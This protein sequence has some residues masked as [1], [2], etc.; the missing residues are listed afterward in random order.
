[1]NKRLEDSA[2]AIT[3]IEIEA[4][5]PKAAISVSA[6]ACDLDLH[7]DEALINPYP[8][9]RRM[10]DLGAVV[11]MERYDMFALGRFKDVREAAANWEVFSSAQGVGLSAFGNMATRG[12]TL[13]S[14]APLHD[15]LRKVV[16]KP[17]LPSAMK[18]LSGQIAEEAES[19][20]EK[21][22]AR[23]EFD[24]VADLAWHL[25]LTIV[26]KLVGIDEQS[27]Q[28]MPA[29]S[30]AAFN[31]FGPDNER[32]KASL[33]ALGE[34]IGYLA[35]PDLRD[36]LA[37]GGWGAQ[38]Y[39]AADRGE[40]DHSHC[41]TMLGDYLGPSLD[42]TMSATASAIWLLGQN[43]DQWA[44]IRE[45]PS[46]IPN[47]VLEVIRLESPIQCFTRVASQDIEIEGVC[48]PAGAR[49][50]LCYGSANRDER[51]WEDPDRCDIRRNV[52]QHLGFGHGVHSCAGTHLAR[53]E[54]QSLLAA[55]VKRVH[56]LELG[57]ADRELN[58]GLRSLRSLKVRVH[59]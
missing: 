28:R 30:A 57:E 35:Q 8:L 18:E 53:L 6:P 38:L 43:P 59:S 10:R 39:A 9:Y 45:D 16:S 41:A 21:L 12:T 48:I 50:M 3:D 40:I 42:T 29:W 49:V 44:L 13:A 46:L 27:R 54:I 31:C 47:A 36:R 58:N 5:Q 20:V 52:F 19:L 17:L 4:G 1:M 34:M 56:R 32:A 24:A 22:V 7:T 11:W 23:G 14:D 33:P 37:P 26:S 15:A 2:Y 25:P 51:R 55:L